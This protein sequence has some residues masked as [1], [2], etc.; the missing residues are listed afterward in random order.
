MTVD[1]ILKVTDKLGT[2][3][4]L[5]LLV[6]ALHKRWLVMGYHYDRLVEDRDR[7]WEKSDRL[8][9]LALRGTALAESWSNVAQ[10]K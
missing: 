4:S 6:L 8:V 2:I 3:L 9:Q 5:V 7:L 10:E 1:M